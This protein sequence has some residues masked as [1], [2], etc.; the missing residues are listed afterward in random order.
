MA[1]EIERKFLVDPSAIWSTLETCET[2][3]IIRQYY[4]VSSKEVAVRLRLDEGEDHAVLAVK[5]GINPM[6]MNEVEFKIPRTDYFKRLHEK[7]GFEISKTRYLLEFENRTW[8]LDEFH[9][10]LEGLMVAEIEADDAESITSFPDWAVEEVTFDTSFKNAVMAVKGKPKAITEPARWEAFQAILQRR[11]E[12][13]VS[14]EWRTGDRRRGELMQAAIAY[15]SYDVS[16]VATV[17]GTPRNWPWELSLFSPKDRR[18]NLLEAGFY[19]LAEEER[20]ALG[21]LDDKIARLKTPVNEGVRKTFDF[22]LDELV[23]VGKQP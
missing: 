23:K 7:T 17:S 21:F 11:D 18:F 22:I 14:A 19:A 20:L 8:E 6:K 3:R 5:N 2:M 4:I 10:Q 15:V 9:G 13:L 1:T 12:K 16:P